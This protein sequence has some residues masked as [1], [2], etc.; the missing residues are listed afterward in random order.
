MAHQCPPEIDEEPIRP[1][2]DPHK[3]PLC[4]S[5]KPVK[6]YQPTRLRL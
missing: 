5:G 4:S 3:R 1:E 2:V 6:G